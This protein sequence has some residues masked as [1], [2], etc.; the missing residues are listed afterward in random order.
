M[1]FV[2]LRLESSV[3]LSMACLCFVVCFS[4]WR[5][6]L[7]SNTSSPA[8]SPR[9]REGLPSGDSC[10]RVFF[11]KA[12]ESQ[13]CGLDGAGSNPT[14][15]ATGKVPPDLQTTK[16]T[17]LGGKLT[18]AMFFPWCP[19]FS[20][21][22]PTVSTEL[23]V[24]A[25]WMDSSRGPARAPVRQFQKAQWERRTERQ[26]GGAQIERGSE[27]GFAQSCP[28]IRMPNI[29]KKTRRRAGSCG[30]FPRS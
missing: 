30:P 9:T 4:F 26:N 14:F 19:L 1:P 17:P 21:W 8:I 5:M 18:T 3:Y 24:N 27:Q 11:P 2:V 13:W 7:A 15:E 10:K 23:R 28:L 20:P 16:I 25:A 6:K 12:A 29:P 22:F